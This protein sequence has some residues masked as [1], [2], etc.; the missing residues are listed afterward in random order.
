MYHRVVNH[1]K[2]HQRWMWMTYPAQAIPV[3]YLKLEQRDAIRAGATRHVYNT[4]VF[5]F[6]Q[7]GEAAGDL[8]TAAALRLPVILNQYN[9]RNESTYLVGG[10]QYMTSCDVS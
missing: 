10:R 9:T 5:P 4:T 2:R 3:G 7:H 1:T 6:A 8:R